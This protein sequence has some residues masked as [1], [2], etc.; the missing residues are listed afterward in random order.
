MHPNRGQEHK[1]A[2]EESTP[3]VFQLKLNGVCLGGSYRAVRNSHHS[4]PTFPLRS[5]VFKQWDLK[6]TV[7][8][9]PGRAFASSWLIIISISL[10]ASLRE[11][12]NSGF[13]HSS[14]LPVFSSEV[15]QG[16][17]SVLGEHQ[18]ESFLVLK[19]L[20]FSQVLLSQNGGASLFVRKLN[21]FNYK[22]IIWAAMS[23]SPHS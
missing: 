12:E 15:S 8:P 1:P 3:A 14:P 18:L 22:F 19:C 17:L 13:P 5:G 11:K 20:G 2:V 23:F 6:Q 16:L 4:N 21:C 9:V 7:A 10:K